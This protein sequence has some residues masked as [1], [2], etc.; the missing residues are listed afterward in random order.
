MKGSFQ[1][2]FHGI[3]SH[4]QNGKLPAPQKSG[5]E[6]EIHSARKPN[7]GVVIFPAES[8]EYWMPVTECVAVATKVP[9]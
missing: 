1:E 3:N 8:M 7:Y 4:G 9:S 2:S 5:T 6:R